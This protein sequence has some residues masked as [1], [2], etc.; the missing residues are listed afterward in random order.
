MQIDEKQ[1][2]HIANLAKLELSEEEK[3][4]LTEDFMKILSYMEKINELDLTGVTETSNFL[5]LN[6]VMREDEI[7]K[8]LPL[9]E[10]LKMSPEH[11]ENQIKVPKFL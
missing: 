11:K 3:A 8:S 9:E 7:E 1:I 2:E 5:A 6:N 4:T 10:V